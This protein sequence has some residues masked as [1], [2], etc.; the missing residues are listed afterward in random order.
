M[1]KSLEEQIGELA[2]RHDLS[3]ISLTLYRHEDGTVSCAAT[4]HSGNLCAWDDLTSRD[5]FAS[6]LESA[7]HELN[8]KR[9]GAVSV[10]ALVAA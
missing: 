3:A 8:K 10:P 9:N 1:S 7:I 2:E 6:A 4:A 5:T